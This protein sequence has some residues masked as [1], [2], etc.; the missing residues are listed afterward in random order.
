MESQLLSEISLEKQRNT[1]PAN[2][3]SALLEGQSNLKPIPKQPKSPEPI[4]SNDTPADMLVSELFESF[5]A[6]SSKPTPKSL[7]LD[8]NPPGMA[9]P[10]LE[11]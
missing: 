1:I 2:L 10:V 4:G 3:G 6:K 7:T 11:F 8:D 5:K 9:I